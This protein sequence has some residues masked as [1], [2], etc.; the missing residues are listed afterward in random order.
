MFVILFVFVMNK[1]LL[2]K[3]SVTI[4]IFAEIY[5]DICV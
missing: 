3:R 4:Y 5:W 1:F 2:P